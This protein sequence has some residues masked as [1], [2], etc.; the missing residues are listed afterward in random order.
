MDLLRGL[1]APGVHKSPHGELEARQW[2]QLVVAATVFSLR[3]TEEER[4]GKAL[5]MLRTAEAL[6]EEDL[7]MTSATQTELR[8]FVQGVL[9]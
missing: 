1:V 3:Y 7:D 8:A 9:L 4:Y 6:I 5:S 2:R